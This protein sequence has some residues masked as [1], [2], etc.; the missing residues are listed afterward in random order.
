MALIECENVSVQ[1]GSYVACENVSF[2]V[3]PGDYLCVVGANGSGK[4]TI[5]KTVT[6]LL[7]AES[8]TVVRNGLECGYLPQKNNIQRDFPASVREVIRSGTFCKGGFFLSK[9]EKLNAEYQIQRLGLESIAGKSFAELSGGQQQRVLLARALCAAKNMIIL[10]EPVTGLDPFVTDELYSIIRSLNKDNGLAVIM[11]SH[12][13]H[14]A[15]QNATHI[16]HMNRKP[17]FFGTVDEY[18]KTPLYSQMS[19]VEVCETHLCNH[20]G[21]DCNASHIPGLHLAGDERKG[22]K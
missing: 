8:G 17:E 9:R 15:V 14:R 3:N 5:V 20:C 6:G 2:T 7:K 10:D 18:E 11:V 4:S 19:N 1:Y 16:L 21:T 22:V 12:D 13:V